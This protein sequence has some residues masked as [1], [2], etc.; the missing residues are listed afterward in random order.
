MAICVTYIKVNNIKQNKETKI[1][2]HYSISKITAFRYGE[3]NNFIT[4][5]TRQ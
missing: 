5:Y 3:L 2:R 1:E 4:T